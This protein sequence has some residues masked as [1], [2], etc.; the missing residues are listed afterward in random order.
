MKNIGV[1]ANCDKPEALPALQRLESKAAELGL[2]LVTMDRMAGALRSAA[3]VSAAQFPRRIDAILALGG[4]GTILRAA[5]IL[6]G[7]DTP[8]LGVNLGKLGFLTSVPEED[9]EK[10]L[11]SL[12]RNRFRISERT[13]ADCRLLRG[14]RVL[15]RYR[16]LNDIVVGWGQS[17]RIITFDV[18][19]NGEQITSYRCDGIIVSTPT[20]T[21]GHSLSAGGP[22]LHPETR[23]LLINVIC[24]HALSARPIVVPDHSDISIG[25]TS[26][27]KKLLLS[28]DGQEEHFVEQGDRL[29]IQRSPKSVRLIL[30]PGY[31]YFSVL[32]KKLQW[33]GSS[34]GT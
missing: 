30:L 17:S 25:V 12:A 16:A 4:D 13:V 33:R 32:R 11:E 8:V 7:S 31:S 29:V 20:G 2:R 34:V 24:P 10:G 23:A 27:Q 6:Q 1:I 28:I 21:T 19:I 3:R 18:A 22:I 26:T 5:R 14:R 15:G 9:L